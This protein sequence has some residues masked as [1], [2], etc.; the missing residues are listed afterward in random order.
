MKTGESAKSERRSRK[1]N[2]SMVY[3]FT[4]KSIFSYIEYVVHAEILNILFFLEHRR[5]EIKLNFAK[6]LGNRYFRFIASLE[7]KW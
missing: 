3:L 6:L 7:A 2:I 4:Q 5:E 1:L